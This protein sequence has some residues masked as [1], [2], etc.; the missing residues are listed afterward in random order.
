MTYGSCM[1]LVDNRA[2]YHG[3]Q[4]YLGDAVLDSVI[5][6]LLHLYTFLPQSLCHQSQMDIGSRIRQPLQAV[7]GIERV[8]ITMIAEPLRQDS[9]THNTFSIGQALVIYS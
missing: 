1:I 8:A 4:L 5:E 6:G 2:I 3:F 9:T 7:G